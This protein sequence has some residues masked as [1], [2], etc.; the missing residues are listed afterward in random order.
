MD[1]MDSNH[2]DCPVQCLR[3]DPTGSFLIVGDSLSTIH[4]LHVESGTV[5]FSEKLSFSSEAVP[6]T[7]IMFQR[8]QDSNDLFIVFGSTLA[9]HLSQ[10]D[11]KEL[12]VA[13]R[14]QNM[15]RLG[16]LKKAV[17]TE[18]VKFDQFSTHFDDSEERAIFDYILPISHSTHRRMILASRTGK[19]LLIEKSDFSEG[20]EVLDSLELGQQQD[21]HILKIDA[22]SDGRFIYALVSS[23]RVA[24]LNTDPLFKLWSLDENSSVKDLRLLELPSHEAVVALITDSDRGNV[25]KLIDLPTGEVL[26]RV[27]LPSAEARIIS[28]LDDSGKLIT[29]FGVQSKTG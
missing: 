25:L 9:V 5:M 22:S 24:V 27:D 20:W 1:L 29:A 8:F 11:T 7:Q 10:V 3:F 16:E 14:C 13:F 26:C 2:P 19:F 4:F 23:G 17:Q 18:L 12:D 21:D 15:A 6:I 28:G